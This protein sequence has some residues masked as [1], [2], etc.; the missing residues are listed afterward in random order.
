MDIELSEKTPKMTQW[1][2]K[3]LDINRVQVFII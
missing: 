1:A 3:T 2:K